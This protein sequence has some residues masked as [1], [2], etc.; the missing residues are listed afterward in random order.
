MNTTKCNGC[1][2]DR[3]KG[4][5]WFYVY[6]EATPAKNA[7]PTDVRCPTCAD[8]TLVEARKKAKAETLVV[9]RAAR[10]QAVKP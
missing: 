7:K 3:A 4:K 10:K 2:Q 9:A 6:A 1:G 5:Q 8:P